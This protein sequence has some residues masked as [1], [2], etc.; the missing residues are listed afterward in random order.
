MQ[1]GA[2]SFTDIGAFTGEENITL[3]GGAEPEVLKGVHVS[4]SFLRILDV[5]P[6]RA[7]VFCRRKIRPAARRLR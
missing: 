3:S 4:A 7:A 2:H 1:S 5:E 6:L